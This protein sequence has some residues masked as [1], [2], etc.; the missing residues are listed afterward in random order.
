[1]EITLQ[2][3]VFKDKVCS[4]KELYYREKGNAVPEENQ[5]TLKEKTE[6]RTNTYLNL[7]DCAIWKKYTSI[8]K[9]RLVMEVKG[10]GSIRVLYAEN[11]TEEVIFAQYRV[12]SLN[13]VK[14]IIALPIGE[15]RYWFELSTETGMSVRNIYYSSSVSE[16]KINPVHISWVICTFQ[17][18]KMIQNIKDLFQNSLFFEEESMYFHGMS[19]RI[20]DNSSEMEVREQPYIKVFHN[21]NT[22]GA[23]G[24]ARGMEE[25]KKE[26]EKYGITQVL[27]MDDDVELM[28]ESLYRLYSFLKIIK[29]EYQ[30]RPIAGRMFRTDQRQI[31]YTALEIWNR[32]EIRHIGRNLD[33]TKME[34]LWDMNHIKETV[35]KDVY[36]G[37]WFGCFPMEYVRK[38]KPLPFFLHCDD[39][40][41]GIRNG[42]KPL[43][44]NGIQV[45]HETYEYRKNAMISYYDIRNSM[46]VN[47]IHGFY[48]SEKDVWEDWKKK[49]DDYYNQ[50]DYSGEY[51]AILAMQDYLKGKNLLFSKKEKKQM[52]E[53]SG[54]KYQYKAAFLWRML[55]MR[56]NRKGHEAFVSYQ[57]ILEKSK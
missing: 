25:S 44:L 8:E 53:K 42:E 17:R 51:A 5:I 14:K 16:E 55:E 6:I 12:D 28:K 31:Q 10:S 22:G 23:G 41:Y 57:K 40:E 46:I 9:I 35:S 54:K 4:L 49:L 21:P 19:M 11:G 34:N 36:T 7:L 18:Q 20:V 13:Y 1:M 26:E 37:W 39:V 3:V 24:F 50:K 47:T 52:R 33:M 15:R 38:H 2:S 56:F 48:Q 43:I 29:P 32:G 45:W 27:L 30:S